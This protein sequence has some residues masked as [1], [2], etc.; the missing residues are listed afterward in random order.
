VL[1]AVVVLVL[2]LADPTATAVL[3]LVY[4][5]AALTV[6]SGAVYAV[7]YLRGRRIPVPRVASGPGGSPVGARATLS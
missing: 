3:A 1:Q 4:A 6:V 5:M 2:V 7:R